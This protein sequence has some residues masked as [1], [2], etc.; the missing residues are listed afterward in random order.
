MK[1]DGCSDDQ[2]TDKINEEIKKQ[3]FLLSVF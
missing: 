1:Y 2:N 3:T